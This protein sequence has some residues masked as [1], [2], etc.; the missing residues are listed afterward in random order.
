MLVLLADA[1]YQLVN[2]VRCTIP[3]CIFCLKTWVA[4]VSHETNRRLLHAKTCIL[5][6]PIRLYL[7]VGDKDVDYLGGLIR[8]TFTHNRRFRFLLGPGRDGLNLCTK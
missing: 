8:S 5:I 1:N 2:F 4:I 7:L 3:C 6:A